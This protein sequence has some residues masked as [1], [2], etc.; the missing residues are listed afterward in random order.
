MAFVDDRGVSEGASVAVLVVLT[1]AVTA[2]VGVGVL[3]ADSGADNEL[4]AEFSFQYFSS[5][6][7]LI[8]T[9]E[10][11]ENISASNVVIRGENEVTWA[12]LSELNESEAV[13]PGTSVQLTENNAYGTE[14]TENSEVS[15][16]YVDGANRTELA[17]W[18]G[19]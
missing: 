4:G 19:G 12:E 18:S 5:R 6:Q 7:A 2:S 8:I 13:T 15:V 14:V 9:Y 1:V 17:T 16:S 3:I 10:D 11:G